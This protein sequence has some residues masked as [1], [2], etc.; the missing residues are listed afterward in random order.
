MTVDRG[1]LRGVY[2]PP[3]SPQHIMAKIAGRIPEHK[4]YV[5]VF[6]GAGL[7]FA[8]PPSPVE[9]YNDLDSGLVS[10]SRSIRKPGGFARLFKLIEGKEAGQA[11]SPDG[12]CAEEWLLDMLPVLPPA[13]HRRGSI[14]LLKDVLDRAM[15]V[16][17]EHSDPHQLIRRYDTPETLFF[18]RPMDNLPHASRALLVQ[19]LLELCGRAILLDL[20]REEYRS[21]AEDGWNRL[22]FLSDEQGISTAWFNSGKSKVF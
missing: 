11:S 14:L 16:Q 17:V 5:E 7:L 18:L 8:K 20:D 9:V 3:C 22:D 4:T 12:R 13:M 2:N 6:G 10:F 21:L 1:R 19:Q 15:R